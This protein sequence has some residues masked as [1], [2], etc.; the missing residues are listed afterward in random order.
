MTKS[1]ERVPSSR[2][3]YVAGYTSFDWAMGDAGDESNNSDVARYIFGQHV[4][5]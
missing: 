1:S 5:S 2:G 3:I 4:N